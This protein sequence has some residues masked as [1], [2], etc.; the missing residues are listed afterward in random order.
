L[1]YLLGVQSWIIAP[2]F[3]VFRPSVVVMRLPLIALNAAVG[4]GLL[5]TFTSRLGIRPALA[6]LAT[7]PFLVPTPAGAGHLLETA[8]ASI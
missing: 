6:F 1:N 7:L 2:C 4:V 3:W 5:V 8:G